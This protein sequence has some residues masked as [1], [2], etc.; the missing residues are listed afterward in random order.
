MRHIKE[1][2]ILLVDDNKVNQLVGEKILS[3]LGILVKRFEYL[4]AP[5]VYVTI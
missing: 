3:K 2:K 4:E 1:E 5:E